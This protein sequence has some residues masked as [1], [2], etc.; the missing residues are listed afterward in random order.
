MR[1]YKLIQI[2]DVTDINS[3]ISYCKILY[4][5]FKENIYYCDLKTLLKWVLAIIL[6]VSQVI[7]SIKN[8]YSFIK[9]KNS[10]RRMKKYTEKLTKFEKR[11]RCK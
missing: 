3:L 8:I 7:T 5:S 9:Y 1:V 2:L 6:G 10:S 11:N 4:A